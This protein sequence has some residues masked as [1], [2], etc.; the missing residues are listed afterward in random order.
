MGAG[1]DNLAR[2]LVMAAA[3]RNPAARLPRLPAGLQAQDDGDK[4]A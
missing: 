2:A 3:A 4:A 1:E